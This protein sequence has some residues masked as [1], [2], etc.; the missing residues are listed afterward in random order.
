M[1]DLP[2]EIPNTPE[3]MSR[4]SDDDDD[5]STLQTSRQNQSP[6][7]IPMKQL[8]REKREDEAPYGS[9]EYV[10]RNISNI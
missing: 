9:P 1:I 3:L 5:N 7:S 6:A 10:E 8:K 2:C 4:A